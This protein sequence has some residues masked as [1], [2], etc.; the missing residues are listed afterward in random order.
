MT[1]R[2]DNPPDTASIVT[3][4]VVARPRDSDAIGKALSSVFRSVQTV[5]AGILVALGKLDHIQ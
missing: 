5:P 3:G 2:N 4:V 1:Y